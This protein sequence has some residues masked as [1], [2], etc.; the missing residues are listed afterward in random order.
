METLRAALGVQ[1]AIAAGRAPTVHLSSLNMLR[2]HGAR[3]AT[4]EA[5]PYPALA[6]GKQRK[7][8]LG[9]RGLS[10]GLMP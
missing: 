10:R 7:L 4:D 2:V 1:A 8:D 3:P 5:R 6:L 9:R